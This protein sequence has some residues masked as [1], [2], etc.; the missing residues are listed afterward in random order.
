MTY[1]GA[2]GRPPTLIFEQLSAELLST[3]GLPPAPD[4]PTD[5]F[6]LGA[7]H[8]Q[9]WDA[10]LPAPA[11]PERTPV[12]SPS[13]QPAHVQT[14]HPHRKLGLLPPHVSES[15]HPRLKLRDYLSATYPFQVPR[16]VDY[17]PQVRG[18][19]V[20]GNDQLGD[21]TAAAAGHAEE[22]WT[23]Y[24]MGAQWTPTDQEV[25]DFY[26]GS[27]GYDP[28]DPSTD[29]GGIMQDVLAYWRKNGL[30]GRTLEAFFQ[31]D[32][33]NADELRAAL[34]LFGCVNIGM[35]FPAYAMDQFDSGQPWDVPKHGTRVNSQIEGGHCVLLVKMV[36]GGNYTV[37]T[38]G[39]LQ[40]V[41]PAFWANYI[42]TR[43]GGEAWAMAE[44]DWIRE[45]S[46]PA[47]ALSVDQLN[48]DFKTLTG[49]PGPFTAS[50]APA[51][52]PPPPAPA[53]S[54][55]PSPAP[56]PS[57]S[58][59]PAPSPGPD[60]AGDRPELLRQLSVDLTHAQAVIARLSE[61]G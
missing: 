58:P 16:T 49:Q 4:P 9:P 55:S 29:Q 24:G 38:W 14:S 33:G 26:S 17:S 59:S 28:R 21:C 12:T 20:M 35:A 34:Y 54:P 1:P 7:H 51:P 37:V 48:A 15:L 19:G 3:D 8:F 39:Q 44:Q 32:P 2:G 61:L 53:P 25:I 23:A 50:P 27:T 30:A 45:G 52:A 18:W 56:S 41:T 13:R 57:P 36:Q 43:A 6:P 31:L 42:G 11:P 10:D 22:V 60:P 47:N 46:A 40:E 5:A